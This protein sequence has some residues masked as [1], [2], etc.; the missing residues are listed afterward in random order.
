MLTTGMW[1]GPMT[2][3]YE[4]YPSFRKSWSLNMMVMVDFRPEAELM[5][6]NR[7]VIP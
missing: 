7:R 5:Q 2:L 3:I 4:I 1:V 6:A